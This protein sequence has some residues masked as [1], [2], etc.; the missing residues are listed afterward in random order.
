MSC[1]CC[2]LSLLR[3][4]LDSPCRTSLETCIIALQFGFFK[5]CAQ[6]SRWNVLEKSASQD[7]FIHVKVSGCGKNPQKLVAECLQAAFSQIESW[8]KCWNTDPLEIHV[9]QFKIRAGTLSKK[10][11]VFSKNTVTLNQKN[12]QTGTSWVS[13]FSSLMFFL[14]FYFCELEEYKWYWVP[15]WKWI[16]IFASITESFSMWSLTGV[17][18]N[19]TNTF[20]A[21]ISALI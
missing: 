5:M 17:S 19:D 11:S 1:D 21:T 14:W 3:Y 13:Y 15:L 4:C 2:F 16:R 6:S 20:L 12:I 8:L 18:F 10:F 7:L 9:L